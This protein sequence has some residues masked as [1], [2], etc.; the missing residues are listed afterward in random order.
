VGPK[1]NI[2][3]AVFIIQDLAISRHQN[4]DGVGQQNH[5]RGHG[6]S[7]AV[8]PFMAHTY[9]LQFDGIHEMVQSHM[10]VSSA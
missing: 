10:R 2:V 9:I 6:T 4:G 8:E 3:A 1:M 7:E 5:P